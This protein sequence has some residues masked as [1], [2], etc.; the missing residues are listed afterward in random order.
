[1]SELLMYHI[2]AEFEDGPGECGSGGAYTEKAET[3]DAAVKQLLVSLR[4]C[5]TEIE[6]YEDL[7]GRKYRK[8]L[9]NGL[10][11]QQVWPHLKDCE[12]QKCADSRQ[13]ME[14]LAAAVAGQ[15]EP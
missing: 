7:P 3:P 9:W 10:A 2:M 8:W 13:R 14:V 15:Y 11:C 1:M 6:V 4:A 12:C 5:P